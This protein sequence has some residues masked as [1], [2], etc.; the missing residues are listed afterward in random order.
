M[1]LFSNLYF[2][3]YFIVYPIGNADL[4]RSSNSPRLPCLLKALRILTDVRSPTRLL[5]GFVKGD[6]PLGASYHSEKFIFWEM[7]AAAGAFSG[8]LLFFLCHC[9][10]LDVD[11]AACKL[12]YKLCIL[13]F[14]TD[15]KGKLIGRNGD[16]AGLFVLHNYVENLGG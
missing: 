13:T 6:L 15:G 12:C 14:L 2:L 3:F 1:L 16:P 8:W 11:L 10:C 9:L 4:Q 5:A 7:L